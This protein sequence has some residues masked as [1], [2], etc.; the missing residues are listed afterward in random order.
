MTAFYF[1]YVFNK[2]TCY[3]I[4]RIFLSVNCL[5][6]IQHPAISIIVI[7]IAMM[8]RPACCSCSIISIVYPMTALY[9]FKILLKD[10]SHFIKNIC[11]SINHLVTI[12]HPAVRIIII[13]IAMVFCPA[14][15]HCSVISVIYP[16]TIA[17][18]FDITLHNTRYRIKIIIF[19]V[20]SLISILHMTFSIIII[21]FIMVHRKI[22]C[23]DARRFIKII[24]IAPNIP[25]SFNH[26][27]RRRIIIKGISILIFHEARKYRLAISLNQH[28]SFFSRFRD[29]NFSVC[30]FGSLNH[31]ICS[32][33][34]FLSIGHLPAACHHCHCQ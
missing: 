29:I 4:K 8:L 23:H 2:C 17:N 26:L 15:H 32:F 33:H 25:F 21:P 34:I 13:C 14:C 6:S 16:V 3:F 10:T 5:A 27:I 18:T 19:A 30:S 28:I 22:S 1:F 7:G 24:P 11:F 9:T 20:N 12:Q 31:C